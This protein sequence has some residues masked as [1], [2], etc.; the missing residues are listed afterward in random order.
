MIEAL[1]VSV[2]ASRPHSL[3]CDDGSQLDYFVYGNTGPTIICVNA[4]GHDLLIF[5]RLIARLAKRFR[6]IAW[7]PRATLGPSGPTLGIMDQVRDL[8][9]LT[10]ALRID[11]CSLLTWCSGAKVAIEYAL[12]HPVDAL[13]LTNGTFARCSE[14]EALETPFERTLFELCRAVVRAPALASTMK[15]SD[16]CL[17][18]RRRARPARCMRAVALRPQ[19]QR[20]ST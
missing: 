12:E 13:A 1:D 6:V 4:H 17:V 15:S 11:R 9:R 18:T 16:R 10:A 7:K 20:S 14:L 5:L 19:T 2:R 8:E 3:R